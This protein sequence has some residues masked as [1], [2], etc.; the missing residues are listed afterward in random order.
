MEIK[1]MWVK[2]FYYFLDA[3]IVNSYIICKETMKKKLITKP[4]SHLMFRSHLADELIGTFC[5]RKKPQSVMT[6]TKFKRSCFSEVGKPHDHM[7]VK[8]K[9]RRCGV[10][11]TK[12]KP[13]KSVYKCASCDIALCMPECFKKFHEN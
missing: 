4:L 12:R 10:C 3:S 1:T 2:A 5:S 13:K 8:C 6:K 9:Q 7:P 11:S